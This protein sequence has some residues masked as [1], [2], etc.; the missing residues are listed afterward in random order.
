M[1][2]APG[3]SAVASLDEAHSGSGAGPVRVLV[4]ED[5]ALVAMFLSDV[6]EDLQYEVCGVASSA[7][8]ALMIAER[9]RPTLALVDIN[10]AGAE[11]GITTACTLRERFSVGS[12]FMSGDSD[13]AVM[14][15][16]KTAQPHGFLHKPY[17]TAQLKGVLEAACTPH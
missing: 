2:H 6:L 16:A 9:E 17:D 3:N 11:D 15:R 5:E 14:E 12:I 13:P 1:T 8:D 10:L 7:A 4:V